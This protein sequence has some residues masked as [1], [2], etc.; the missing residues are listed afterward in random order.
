MTY[1]IVSSTFTHGP[2][3]EDLPYAPEIAVQAGVS[4]EDASAMVGVAWQMA[5]NFTRR[6]YRSV[7]TGVVMVQEEGFDWVYWPVW[8][9]PTEITCE[10]LSGR[11]WVPYNEGFYL[12]GR[13]VDLAGQGLYR[14]TQVGTVEAPEIPAHVVAA[15]QCLATYLLI[16]SPQRREFKTQGAGDTS[17]SRESYMGVLYGSGAGAM[18]AS[19]VRL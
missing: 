7:L 12:P 4:A 2:W 9:D 6:A 18:L 15:V 3:P 1:S 8:P 13:G 11:N 19:E 14:L 10:L 17:F 5:S 16:Q